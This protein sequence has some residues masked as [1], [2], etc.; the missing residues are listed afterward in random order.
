MQEARQIGWRRDAAPSR[1]LPQ[2]I[3]AGV[4]VVRHKAVVAAPEWYIAVEGIPVGDN[5]LRFADQVDRLPGAA[6][7]DH[8]GLEG[9]GPLDEIG[10]G[11]ANRSEHRR[12]VVAQA[13]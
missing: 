1:Q 11:A 5:A 12:G 8:E 3:G 2:L 10:A 4:E 7:V 9:I 13:A 6:T